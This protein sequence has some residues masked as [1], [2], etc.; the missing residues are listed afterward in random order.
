MGYAM[1]FYCVR[2]DE[3]TIVIYENNVKLTRKFNI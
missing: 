3:Q 1:A 2:W